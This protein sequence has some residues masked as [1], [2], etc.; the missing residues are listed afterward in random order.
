LRRPTLLI[1][2]DHPSNLKLLR[3]ALEDEYE[4]VSALDAR[5]AL[6]LLGQVVPD[7]VLLDVE[8]PDMDGLELARRIRGDARCRYVPILA[9]SAHRD[10]EQVAR[11]RA[12]GCVDYLEKPLELATLSAAVSRHLAGAAA[13]LTA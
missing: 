1:V 4:L 5:Q 6:A 3:A 2:D 12:A 8:L 11:A 10:A 7:L 13:P 9:L